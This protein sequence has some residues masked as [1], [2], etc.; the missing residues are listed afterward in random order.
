MDY[1]IIIFLLAKLKQRS[2]NHYESQS[3][4]LVNL[5]KF[6][7]R[8]KSE[9]RAKDDDFALRH[10]QVQWDVGGGEVINDLGGLRWA[11]TSYK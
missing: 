3:H 7:R 5:S 11:L 6:P 1:A 2:M 10:G 9:Q 4:P 8:K